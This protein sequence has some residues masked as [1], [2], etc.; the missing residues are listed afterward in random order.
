M[1]DAECADGDAGRC[2]IAL[3]NTGTGGLDLAVRCVYRNVGSPPAGPDPSWC[4][5][6]TV[7]LVRRLP[8]GTGSDYHI[9]PDLAH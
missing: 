8:P 3:H 2:A 7:R 6:T 1:T 9:C 4:A 5:G